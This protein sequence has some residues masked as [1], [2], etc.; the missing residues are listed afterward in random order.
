MIDWIISDTYVKQKKNQKQDYC[1]S[2]LPAVH[3]ILC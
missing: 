2:A 1:G 3:Y